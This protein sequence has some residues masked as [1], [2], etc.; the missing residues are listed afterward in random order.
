MKYIASMG[1]GKEI[2]FNTEAERKEWLNANCVEVMSRELGVDTGIW[3]T[4]LRNEEVVL[5]ER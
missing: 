1:R 3:F 4:W 5:L 2:E